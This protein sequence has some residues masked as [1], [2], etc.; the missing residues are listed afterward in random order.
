M[1][2]VDRPIWHAHGR[3]FAHLVS[4]ESLDELH[5][6]ATRLGLPIR[7]F[8]LDHYDLPDTWWPMA[9]E[10]G[11]TEVDPRELTR[12]LRAAGLR[13]R[14]SARRGSVPSDPERR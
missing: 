14:P 10:L 12:R 9:V 6:F 2:L 1:I 3:R 5:G 8:H 4:D 7:A 11:A 13:V